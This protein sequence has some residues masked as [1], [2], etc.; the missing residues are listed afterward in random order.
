MSRSAPWFGV[1]VLALIFLGNNCAEAR[2]GGSIY[3]AKRGAM[4]MR[5]ILK[6]TNSD[7]PEKNASDRKK[8]RSRPP[9]SLEGGNGAADNR[10]AVSSAA[11]VSSSSSSI[12]QCNT[13]AQQAIIIDYDTG[14][15][16][17]AKQPQE[18]CVPSSM[19]KLMTIYL[20]FEALADGRIH[21]DDELVVS[22]RA[23]KMKGS[24][25]FFEAGSTVKLEDVIR[26]IIV[27]SGNDGCVVFTEKFSGDEDAFA[28]EMNQKAEEFGL[29]NTNFVN[30]T[31]LPD[32]DHYSSVE[33]IALL[34]KRLLTDFPQFYHYFSEK[35]F[36]ANGI[37]QENRN[38]LLGNSLNVDGLKTGF[39]NNGGYGV[40][41][42]AQKDGK[43]LILVINGCKSSRSRAREAS[44]LLAMGFSE[45]VSLKIADLAIPVGT[46][47]VSVGKKDKV[48]LFVKKPIVISIPKRY[49]RSLIV[50]LNVPS[51]I[52]APLATGTKVGGLTYRYGNFVSAKYDLFINESIERLSF[53]ERIM[54]FMTNLFSSKKSTSRAAPLPIG[55]KPP[56]LNHNVGNVEKLPSPPPLPLG[57]D[58]PIAKEFH[59]TTR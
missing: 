21:L 47:D 54:L 9:S 4:A 37:T 40:A 49:R 56:K 48:G 36:T 16:L 24:R 34:S 29:K 57:L 33:D 41:I 59:A 50:E 1:F 8:K 27:H 22:E 43:R 44:R 42:S 52:P 23:Q 11:A 13:E 5:Q 51:S 58:Q 39:T 46:V 3:I 20:L 15:V 14:D 19:T 17:F 32:P 26:S 18:K 10:A 31:G 38:T 25:S 12:M 55:L 28:A 35:T 7:R 30:S 53:F 45:F 2:I 6:K